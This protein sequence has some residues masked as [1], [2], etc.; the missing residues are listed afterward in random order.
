MIE[1]SRSAHFVSVALPQAFY[2]TNNSSNPLSRRATI[3]A[4]LQEAMAYLTLGAL[5]LVVTWVLSRDGV[6]PG[7]AFLALSA[8]LATGL[9]PLV[10]KIV[11]ET[12]VQDELS[13]LVTMGFR[14]LVLL[15]ALAIS[16]ATKWQHNNSFG[17]CL[18]GYYFPF[19]LLQSALLIRNQPIQHPPQS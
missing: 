15:G 3:L 6:V 17:S 8:C 18:M 16:A 13:I 2:M 9:V 4:V 19:L 10:F 11:G 14:F 5:C 7:Y 1:G 12:K